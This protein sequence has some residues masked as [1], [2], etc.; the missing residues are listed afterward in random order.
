[1]HVTRLVCGDAGPNEGHR[2]QG[3]V[4]F[5]YR[6]IG[7]AQGPNCSPLQTKAA[8]TRAYNKTTH[9]MP[10]A[11]GDIKKGRRAT[12]VASAGQ[13]D[14]HIDTTRKLIMTDAEEDFGEGE[15]ESGG[16]ESSE[17][18]DDGEDL[19]ASRMVTVKAAPKA[20]AAAG[21]KGKKTASK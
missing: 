15:G 12:A 1:M 16:E 9:M 18:S 17:E 19:T 11:E 3:N 6:C 7:L 4:S 20:K 21:A 10:Y 8:L 13:W 14:Q 5:R 2:L